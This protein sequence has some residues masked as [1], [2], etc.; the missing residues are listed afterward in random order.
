MRMYLCMYMDS[1]I[2]IEQIKSIVVSIIVSYNLWRHVTMYMDDP[3]PRWKNDI[4]SVG[5]QKRYS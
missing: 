5:I 2:G 4:N 1:I 3:R